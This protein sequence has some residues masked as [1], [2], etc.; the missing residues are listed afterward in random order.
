[1]TMIIDPALELNSP[2][3]MDE[4]ISSYQYHSYFPQ[5]P[6]GVNQ[7][8]SEIRFDI[9]NEDLFLKPSDAYIEIT[10]RFQDATTG[11]PY[12]GADVATFTNNAMGF[13][14]NSTSYSLNG[15]QIESLTTSV[16]QATLMKAL[17]TQDYGFSQT[18]GLN[19]GFVLDSEAGTAAVGNLGYN[20]RLVFFRT[21]N[22]VGSF[23]FC[24]PLSWYFGFCENYQ[25]AIYG[26][27]HTIS[28]TRNNNADNNVLFRTGGNNGEVIIDTMQLWVP[29]VMPND[30]IRSQLTAQMMTRQQIPVNYLNRTIESQ[31]VPAASSNWSWRLSVQANKPR[32]IVVAFQVARTG[33]DQTLNAARFDHVSCG[34]A[35]IKLNSAKYPLIDTT[36]RFAALNYSRI[37]KQYVDFKKTL[38]RDAYSPPIIPFEDFKNLYT[39]YCFDLTRQSEQIKNTVYDV[40]FYAQFTNPIPVGPAITE[41][42]ALILSDKTIS[43]QSDGGRMTVIT[44]ATP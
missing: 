27:K 26:C 43:L 5:N 30:L 39:L 3:F 34:S 29:Q 21:G 35:Y 20:R 32:F 28:F 25:K 33:G 11:A 12:A 16:G 8:G 17:V 13:L 9:N 42:F 44:N 1:M 6:T 22:P 31:V 38:T 4:S 14:F 36:S 19:T 37:Y 40:M 15:Q 7:Y 2:I 18:E 24:V 23:S 10:G 41:A